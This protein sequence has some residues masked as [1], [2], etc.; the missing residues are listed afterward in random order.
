MTIDSVLDDVAKY[1]IKSE[2]NLIFFHTLF[3]HNPYGFDENCN[4][5]G[6]KSMNQYKHDIEWKT[7]QN[8]IERICVFKKLEKLFKSLKSNNYWEDLNVVVLS[9]HGSRISKNN[10]EMSYLSSIFAV[11]SNEHKIVNDKVST[12]FLFSKLFNI[13]HGN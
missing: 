8:N 10:F 4:Y 7:S 1:T 11:K 12:Q 6:S 3:S 9:D 2:T 13:Y 5:D